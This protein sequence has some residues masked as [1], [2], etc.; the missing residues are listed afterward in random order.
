MFWKLTVEVSVALGTKLKKQ[1]KGDLAEKRRVT[2]HNKSEKEGK[3]SLRRARRRR[4]ELEQRK[5]S[6]E[7]PVP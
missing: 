7:W 6:E 3:G 4:R 1:T 5:T 2:T